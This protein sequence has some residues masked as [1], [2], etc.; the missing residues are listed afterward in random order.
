VLRER[1][2]QLWID[3]RADDTRFRHNATWAVPLLP[4]GTTATPLPTLPALPAAPLLAGSGTATYNPGLDA[5]GLSFSWSFGDG[6]PATP[7]GASSTASK[8]W[9][10]PGIYTVTLTVRNTAGDSRSTSFVQAVHTAATA[11]AARSSTAMLLEPRSGA[12]ARLWVINPDQDNV[13]VI[14]SATLV[15]SAV[16]PVG[17]A[18]RSIARAP[19][20]T[21]WVL[22][23]DS[24]SISVI[25]ASTL[26]VT[27]TVALPRA[28]QPQGLV[29]APD[30]SAAWVTLGAAARLLRL[31]PATGAQTG[32]WATGPEPRGLAISGDSA[33]LL[34]SRFVAGALPGEGTAA[35]TTTGNVGGEVWV[36]ATA[37]MAAPT[38]VW[39]RHSDRTDTEIQGSGVPN[40]L[41]APVIAPEGRAAWVPSKQD[42]ISRGT[43][44]NGVNLDF[45]NTVHAISSRIDLA[46]ATPAELPA[47]RAD[48]DNARLASAAV[49]DPTGAYLFVAL[50]T[51]R[52]VAVLDAV[53]GTELVRLEA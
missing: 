47:L 22:N 14:D 3:P 40:Y 7:F 27:R 39:L 43:L 44:R 2:G 35:V 6:T 21:L 15:R 45:Q 20:G 48:H 4:L 13:A 31:D 36:Y 18:P 32:A 11:S 26:A 12:A 51:S 46:A 33:R 30:G 41:G 52:Q 38:T 28:S 50:E 24:A 29:F 37:T 1:D 42:N 17:A 5:A 49:F 10:A 19:D 25:D 53:R 8:S 16:V 34:V 9:A 23:R